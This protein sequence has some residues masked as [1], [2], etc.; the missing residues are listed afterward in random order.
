VAKKRKAGRAYSTGINLGDLLSEHTEPEPEPETKEPTK[1]RLKAR[2]DALKAKAA[3][4][5][6]PWSEAL[7]GKLRGLATAG[8]IKRAWREHRILHGS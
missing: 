3:Q 8:A 2:V 5:N 4:E 6:V 1:D 7:E